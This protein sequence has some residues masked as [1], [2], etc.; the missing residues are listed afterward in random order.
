MF[1]EMSLKLY[2]MKI[3]ESKVSECIFALQGLQA[4]SV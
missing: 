3:S 4:Q 1:P 2:F